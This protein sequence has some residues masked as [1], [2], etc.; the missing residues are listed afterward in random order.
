M[1]KP[2]RK[3]LSLGLG[4]GLAIAL[5]TG[6]CGN[7][8]TDNTMQQPPDNT[9]P[10]MPAIGDG[11]APAM[12]FDHDGTLN[13][14]S[15]IFKDGNQVSVAEGEK[16]HSCGK[17]QVDT[18][19]RILSSRGVNLTTMTLHSAGLLYATGR[20]VL[21]SANYPQRVAE[22]D[23][24]TTGGLVRLYDIIIAAVEELLPNAT[25]DRLGSAPNSPCAGATLFNP[26][27]TCNADGI[28]CFV[29]VPP[30]PGQLALCNSMV[31]NPD[32][33]FEMNNIL[34]RKRLAIAALASPV[35]LCD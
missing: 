34:V 5:G 16:L 23:R 32:V 28:A 1:S 11:N 27:N 22:S 24:N 6:S 3:V 30:T 12:A 31:T 29:G 20:N 8:G 25:T 7:G 2:Q 10:T 21:G 18:L 15:D 14:T 4:L 33:P 35:F 9:I 13:A 26:D 19:S 17:I